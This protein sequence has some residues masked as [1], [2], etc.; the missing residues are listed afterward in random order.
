LTG[1]YFDLEGDGD[2]LRVSGDMEAGIPAT[3]EAGKGTG[4]PTYNEALNVALT[5]T[6]DDV[7]EGQ[8][9]VQ[10]FYYD[11][12]ALYGGDTFPVFQDPSIAP[13][14]TLFDQSALS[15]EKYGAKLTY[16]RDNTFWEGLQLATGIDFLH[17]E[18]YQELAQTGR[19]WVPKMIYQGWAPFLQ[20][21]Q[22]LL[23][24]RLRLSAGVRHEN[25]ELEVPGFTTI[26]S[27]NSTTVPGGNPSFEKAL[28]NA[29]IVFDL[30]D[31]LSLFASYA[32]GFT[33]PDAGLILRAVNTP[34]QSVDELVDL[35]PVIADNIEIGASYHNDGLEISGSY[36]WSDSDLGSRIQ[37]VNG[38]GQIRREKTEIEGLELALNYRFESGLTTGVTYSKL[39]GRYDS[40]GDGSVDRDLDGR[41]IAPDRI[42]LFVEGPLA[43][44]WNARLQYSKLLDRDFD[45]GLPE[46]DF[47]GYSLVDAI[48]S[49]Q[50][51]D[52][53]DFSIGIQN[54]LNE[55]YIT[56]YSQ[57]V[58]FVN[59][60]TFVAGRG[61]TITLGWEKAF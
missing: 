50:S 47:D 60:D 5:Y 16:I 30:T 59:D 18:T 37:V 33:M 28:T 52:L 55:E 26:A 22:R 57:T 38:A 45:G 42:N 15:S 21:E 23:D 10:G 4:D 39:D 53:G 61:R 49:Y 17:D 14:G 43:R 2:Y 34:G 6:H 56:Y 58:T 36:F 31:N 44:N 51:H 29:G 3:S 13:A 46:H 54:L 9:T 20:L 25:V 24:D 8:L 11:F 32:E 48:V 1:N 7:Y 19:L 41:N 27:A 12:Y 35:Q 40:D